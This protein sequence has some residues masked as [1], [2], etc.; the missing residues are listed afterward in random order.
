MM[1]WWFISPYHVVPIL[2]YSNL[3]I[4]EFYQSFKKKNNLNDENEYQANIKL[5][6]KYVKK[7]DEKNHKYWRKQKNHFK[8]QEETSNEILECLKQMQNSL[9]KLVEG[10]KKILELQNGFFQDQKKSIQ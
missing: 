7:L 9:S 1:N 8:Q 5:I 3:N 6:L 4:D 2:L 10:M